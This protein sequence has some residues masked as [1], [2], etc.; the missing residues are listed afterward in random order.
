MTAPKGR[1][2]ADVVAT[3]IMLTVAATT[4]SLSL[5]ISFFFAM[6]TD[7]CG[8]NCNTAALDWVYPVTWGGIAIGAIVAIAGV[9]VAANRGRV[10]WVWPTI[11]VA[12]I[13]VTFVIGGEL[14]NSV[15]P[16]H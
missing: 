1:S 3:V 7:A 2:T 15:N 5:L 10:M 13:V 4:A 16:H 9:A 8:D 11:A 6:A 12:L 14:A